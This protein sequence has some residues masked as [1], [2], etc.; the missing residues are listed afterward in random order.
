LISA[1]EYFKGLFRVTNQLEHTLNEAVLKE[2]FLE[3]IIWFAYTGK[4]NIEG[5]CVQELLIAANYLQLNLQ[6]FQE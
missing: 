3:P 4:I 1:S 5:N 2:F 6:H